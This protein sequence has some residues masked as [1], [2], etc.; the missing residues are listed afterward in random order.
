[1]QSLKEILAWAQMKVSL[2]KI[3]YLCQFST[4]AHI[5]LCN[6]LLLEPSGHH[7]NTLHECYR[8]IENVHGEIS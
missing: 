5:E 1:M 2:Y 4:T 3:I 8:H 6:Q 7:F